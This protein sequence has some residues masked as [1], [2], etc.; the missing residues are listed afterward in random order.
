MML[1]CPCDLGDTR[2]H[3]R[4]RSSL[5]PCACSPTASCFPS[6]RAGHLAS[7]CPMERTCHA[8]GSTAHA[9]RDC[10]N[11]AK[12]CD[13]CGRIGHLKFKCRMAQNQMAP[14]QQF[15]GFGGGFGG[16]G[17]GGGKPCDN[18]GAVGHLAA[19]CPSAPQCHC[20]GSTSHTKAQCTKLGAQC[21]LCGKIGHLKAKCRS[22]Y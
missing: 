18:C 9:K 13:L 3:L 5:N 20:C 2:A 16:F 15:G 11:K 8:C 21:D 4:R 12:M 6:S 1:R 10:P 22:F 14:Q 7:R 17:G 19:Q